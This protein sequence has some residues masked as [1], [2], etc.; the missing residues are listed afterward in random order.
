LTEEELTVVKKL[1][2]TL[3]P[4][5]IV[6]GVLEKRNVNMLQGDAALGVL[7]KDLERAGETWNIAKQLHEELNNR[8]ESRTNINLLSALCF[9]VKPKVCV[10]NDTKLNYIKLY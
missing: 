7:L 9:L 3:S 4:I 2:N 6:I 5:A 10:D 8:L 1:V